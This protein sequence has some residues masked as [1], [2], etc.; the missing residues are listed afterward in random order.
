MYSRELLGLTILLAVSIAAQFGLHWF[1]VC[2]KLYGHGAKFPTG[3][4]FWRW[5][6]ELRRYR[7]LLAA[8]GEDPS[9]YHIMFILTWF[10][11]LLAL[12]VVVRALWEYTHPLR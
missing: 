5:F 6:K 10:N 8:R 11:F 1:R 4:L 2:R 7:D 9:S 3:F 12:V